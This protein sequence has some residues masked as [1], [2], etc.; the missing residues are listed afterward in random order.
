MAER[1]RRFLRRA[2]RPPRAPG[3]APP[4][5][6]GAGAAPGAGA[7]AAGPETGVG[8][9]DRVNQPLRDGCQR[10][11]GGLLSYTSPEWVFVGG[12]EA[13]TDRVVEGVVTNN[14]PADED[15][16]QSHFSYDLDSDVTPDPQYSDLLA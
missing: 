15:L 8:G 7:G 12:H 11:P 2:A 16:P 9:P 4:P 1:R 13:G 10:N 5:T 6:P 3:R 14:H